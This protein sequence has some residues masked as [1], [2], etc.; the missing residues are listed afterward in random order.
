LG[1]GSC[2]QSWGDGDVKSMLRVESV[3]IL[4]E[5]VFRSMRSFTRR[6][7]YWCSRG[8]SNVLWW[9]CSVSRHN[10]SCICFSIDAVTH[11]LCCS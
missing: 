2:E 4:V 1:I 8:V 11:T 10:C 5:K 3:L 6:P 9:G 7:C